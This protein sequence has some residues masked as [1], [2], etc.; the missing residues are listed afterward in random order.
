M[1]LRERIARAVS[2]YLCFEFAEWDVADPLARKEALAV[3]DDV[4]DA[5]RLTREEERAE[6][7]PELTP[8]FVPH[9][10]ERYVTPWERPN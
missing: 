3:A 6:P 9:T 5:L 4:I 10:V 8:I 2:P 1:E 7:R